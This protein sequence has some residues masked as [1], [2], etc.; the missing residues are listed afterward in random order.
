MS[1]KKR[2]PGEGGGR[3][4]R[5]GQAPDAFPLDAAALPDLRFLEGL[6]RQH[7]RQEGAGRG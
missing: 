7:L 6:L 1:K 4:G 5:K 3:R 2:Q